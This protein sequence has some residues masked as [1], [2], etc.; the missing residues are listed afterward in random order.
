V[1]SG[2]SVCDHHREIRLVVAD[3]EVIADGDDLFVLD[4]IAQRRIVESVQHA[5]EAPGDYSGK[6]LPKKLKKFRPLRGGL[7]C[8]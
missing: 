2:L 1:T 6:H 4:E 7:V 3:E 5:V 8:S